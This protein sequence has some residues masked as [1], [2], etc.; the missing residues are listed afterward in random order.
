MFV[1]S[2]RSKLMLSDSSVEIL[3]LNISSMLFSLLTHFL[4]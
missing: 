1:F 3:K 4:N 2:E